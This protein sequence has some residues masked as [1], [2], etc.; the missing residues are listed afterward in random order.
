MAAMTTALTTAS[1]AMTSSLTTVN[2]GSNVVALCVSGA[3]AAGIPIDPKLLLCGV[4][5]MAGSCYKLGATCAKRQRLDDQTM[6]H[7]KQIQQMQSD[8]AQVQ[9]YMN[10]LQNQTNQNASSVQQFQSQASQSAYQLQNQVSIVQGQVSTTHERLHTTTQQLHDAGEQTKLHMQQLQGEVG[11]CNGRLDGLRDDTQHLRGLTDLT[12]QDLQQMDDQSGQSAQNLQKLH[13][14][15]NRLAARMGTQLRDSCNTMVDSVNVALR[16]RFL[17][18][19]PPVQR[20]NFRAL[21]CLAPPLD[22]AGASLAAR[23]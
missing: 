17:G 1:A 11:N 22:A 15:V 20:L 9:S 2:D 18:F 21:P 4:S 8:L 13:G 3:A 12:M 23:G 14:D 5:I 6:H 19:G 16:Q 10:Q 7:S